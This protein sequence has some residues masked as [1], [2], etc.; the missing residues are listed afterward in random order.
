MKGRGGDPAPMCTR[1]SRKRE[2][3]SAA[4]RWWMLWEVDVAAE[5]CCEVKGR[6]SLADQ[7]R[8]RES[9]AEAGGW[10]PL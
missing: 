3:R 4:P 9:R 6:P 7:T 8:P 2:R 5:L 10:D 1:R